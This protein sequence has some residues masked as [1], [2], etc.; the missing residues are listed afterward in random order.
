MIRNLLARRCLPS[1][2][3]GIFSVPEWENRRSEI[4]E[5]LC[6]EEYGF[7]P[8]TP[9]ELSSEVVSSEILYGG[10]F[11]QKTVR[12]TA[13]LPQGDFSFDIVSLFPVAKGKYPLFIN[14]CFRPDVPDRYLPAEEI[15]DNGFGIIAVHHNYISPDRNSFDTLLDAVMYKNG[16]KDDDC[17]KIGLWSWAASRAMD[18]AQTLDCVDLKNVCVIGHSRLGKTALL[19]GAFDERFAFVVSN[20]GGCSG[21]ALS[22]GKNGERI[23]DITRV[24]PYWFCEN[25]KKYADN[26]QMQPFDQ[27]YL[28]AL[29]APR[30][31]MVGAAVEDL[32]ADPVSQFLS[33]AA[34]D[35]VYALYSK[36]ALVAPD[37]LPVPGD[38][39]DAGCVAFHLRAGTH[40]ITRQDWQ[41]Y[42]NYIKKHINR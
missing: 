10:K 39:F 17:G 21:E 34:V 4:K 18:Y 19:T 35:N 20:E 8:S 13:T 2:S 5:L 7:L 36:K 1:P 40:T 31:V 15:C 42:M 30:R 6:R 9:L 41:V 25:Y 38:N 26:E 23:S 14:L 24:F 12:L 11:E 32:W 16:R 3:E 29:C 37:R 28:L 22:R 33:C 27:H